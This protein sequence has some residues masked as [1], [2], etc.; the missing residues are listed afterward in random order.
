MPGIRHLD[1]LE[2]FR[3]C[4]ALQRETWGEGFSDVVPA[5]LLQV[6]AKIGGLLAG[7]FDAGRLIGFVYS[8]LALEDDDLAHWSHMLAVHPAARGSGLGR[9][10]KLFQRQELLGRGIETVLW[11]F[12]PMVARN[13]HLN[14]NRLGA[15]IDRFVPDMYG[16]DT[17]SPLHAG[18]ETDRLIVRWELSGARARW[19]IEEGAGPHSGAP[20]DEESVVHGPASGE[21][22]GELPEGDEVYVEIPLDLGAPEI[23]PYV[24]E[25]RATVRH[26]FSTYLRRGYAVQSLYRDDAR[27][28]CLYFL[29]RG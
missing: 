11:S 1:S 6:S 27:G 4:V 5:S 25:W 18:G 12:D 28:R 8:L 9:R 23:E 22:T 7:A 2:D 26:A 10:L 16:S 24:R 14:L 19:A 21:P 17:G 20:P 13:A 15:T 3:A 29:R